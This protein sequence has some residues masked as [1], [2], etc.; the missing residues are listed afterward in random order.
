[1][2]R[3]QNAITSV[4]VRREPCAVTAHHFGAWVLEQA[5]AAGFDVRG[6]APHPITHSAPQARDEQAKAARPA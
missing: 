5:A 1:M 6:L 2:T 3:R 4:V